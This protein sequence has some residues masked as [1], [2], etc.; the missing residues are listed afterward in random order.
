MEL[1]E[2]SGKKGEN[3]AKNMEAFQAL[4]FINHFGY[5]AGPQDI[6]SGMVPA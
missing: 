4:I 5:W 2:E 6:A 3:K 1:T